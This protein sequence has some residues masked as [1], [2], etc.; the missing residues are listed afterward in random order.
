MDKN[1]SNR[2]RAIRI[3]SAIDKLSNFCL[4]SSLTLF[5]RAMFEIFVTE[6]TLDI[7]EAIVFLMIS[8]YMLI[9]AC[10]LCFFKRDP[11]AKDGA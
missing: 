4:A 3:N 2:L 7:V 8:V 9:M 1:V 5:A 10:S 11:D 6:P